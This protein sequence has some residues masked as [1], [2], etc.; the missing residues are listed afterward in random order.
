MR[1][2]G[3]VDVPRVKL[4]LDGL[5]VWIVC[6]F[7][8]QAEDG[9]RDVAVTGVQT[10]ALPISRILDGGARRR[11]E[12]ARRLL[13]NRQWAI[14]RRNRQRISPH[15]VPVR[16]DASR[17][18]ENEPGNTID[19]SARKTAEHCGR[20]VHPRAKLPDRVVLWVL[21]LLRSLH[22][23]R[24]EGPYCSEGASADAFHYANFVHA[25]ARDRKSNT[26]ELQSRLHLV[27]RLLLEKKKNTRRILLLSLRLL[28]KIPI[29]SRNRILPRLFS[30]S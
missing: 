26:S 9:I 22:P 19:R 23:P 30:T 15:P 13:C 7:F 1:V 20:R 6:V 5:E 16:M 18:Q 10:C 11:Q 17:G 25:A 28:R 12:F 29:F 4:G 27:C 8:F 14:R 2:E 3:S 21:R 24:H